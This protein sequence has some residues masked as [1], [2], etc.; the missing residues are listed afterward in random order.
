MQLDDLR[1]LC[2]ENLDEVREIGFYPE[3]WVPKERAEITYERGTEKRY[4]VTHLPM[5]IDA[6]AV[7]PESGILW[8]AKNLNLNDEG[9]FDK[10]CMMFIEDIESY[11]SLQNPIADQPEPISNSP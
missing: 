8:Y 9:R 3:R 6:I 5:V 2:P 10:I 1:H 7:N 11:K 4:M